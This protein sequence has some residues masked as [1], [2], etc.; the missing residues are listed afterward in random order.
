MTTVGG[1]DAIRG[2]AY[3]QAQA[4]LAALDVL[5]DPGL[6]AMRVEGVDDVVDIEI[7]AT[8]GTL[9]TAKQVKIRHERYTWGEAEIVTIL[10]RWAQL[11]DAAHASFEFLTDGRLGPTGEKLRDALDEAA[12][13][14]RQ[15]LA[16]LLQEDG[17]GPVCANLS[18]TRLRIDSASVGSLLLRAERQVAAML[19]DARTLADAREDSKRAVG[20]LFQ[21]LF[22]RGGNPDPAHR[23]LTREQIAA[24]L[25]VPAGQSPSQRWPGAIRRRYLSAAGAISLDSVVAS[26]VDPQTQMRPLIRHLDSEKGGKNVDASVML[27]SGGPVTL[28]GRTGTGK[29]TTARTLCRDAALAGHVVLLAHAETYLPGRLAALASDAISDLL[30]ED[31][32]F[33]TGRQALADSEVTMII[34]GV[35]EVPATVRQALHDDLVAPTAASRGA[36]IM[37]VGRDVAALREVLPSSVTPASYVMADLDA[38]QRFELAFRAVFDRS[39]GHDDQS[40]EVQ[41]VR[42]LVAQVDH[43]LGDATGNPLL[44]TMGL[45]LVAEGIPFTTRANLYDAFV[46]RLAARAGAT[47]IV[48]ASRALGIVYAKLLT[49]GRRYADP[50]EWA[51]LMTE[52]AARLKVVGAIADPLV[53]DTAVRRSGL[54]TPIGYTQTLAPIHDSFADYLA[55]TAHALGLVPLPDRL[56]SGDDQRILFAA[57]VGGVDEEMAALVVRDQPFL[58]VRVSEFDCRNLSEAAPREVERLLC[59]LLPDETGCSV[60]LWRT[61]D[62]RVV[63]VRSGAAQSEWVDEAAARRHLLTM[64]SVVVQDG[65]PLA[66]AV[67]LWRQDL[68]AGLLAPEALGSP[69]PTTV[70]QACIALRSHSEQAAAA[71]KQLIT[72]V[73]PRGHASELAARVG[74]VGL[75]ATVHPAEAG[76]RGHH[77][78]VSY[79]RSED[80]QVTIS[81]SQHPVWSG[82][83]TM[84]HT[85]HTSVDVM[86]EKA[87]ATDAA[88]RV[89]D[90]ITGLTRQGWL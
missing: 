4:L 32:P 89:R 48:V 51:E 10:R 80:V 29:S 83:S 62:G 36:R 81:P 3:Q 63:A 57:E 34:D 75:T 73:A 66:V 13:G 87:P 39:P 37:L 12:Q 22:E 43:A 46:A 8:D 23:L 71:T 25:G 27:H 54:I 30:A 5:D 84:R 49:S 76:L 21:L 77:W 82:S 85:S 38:G 2:I 90:A 40:M 61:D 6:G 55:G 86:I 56:R 72:A 15:A 74:P 41:S 44:F 69:W 14:H 67:R 1:T 17:D 53:L 31:L 52:A 78:P 60:A 58:A 64:P 88:K 18:N 45:T 68:L 65:G 16:N 59:Y 42:T 11:A 24:T 7:F 70:E 28:A 9:H 20:T 79:F 19:V 35:S 50:Y 33:A 47:N 26:R